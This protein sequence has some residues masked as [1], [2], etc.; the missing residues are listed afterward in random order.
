MF[1]MYVIVLFLSVGVILSSVV[2]LNPQKSPFLLV[3]DAKSFKEIAR[4]S[5]NASVH[6]DLHGLFIRDTST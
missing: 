3:L 2:S 1:S 4:A 6:M 5:I